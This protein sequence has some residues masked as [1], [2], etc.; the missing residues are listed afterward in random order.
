MAEHGETQGGMVGG[1][2]YLWIYVCIYIYIYIYI[3][4][5]CPPKAAHKATAD[6]KTKTNAKLK[7]RA[8]KGLTICTIHVG[9]GVHVF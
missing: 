3:R 2:I 5:L 1:Y 6:N 7:I 4:S 9:I 8:K